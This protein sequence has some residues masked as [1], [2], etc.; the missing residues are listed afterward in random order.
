MTAPM[1]RVK[2]RGFKALDRRMAGA[3]EAMAFKSELVSALGGEVDLSPQRRK[4]VDMAARTALLLD[5]VDAWIVEQRTLVNQRNRTLLPI[6]TQRTHLADHLAR[7]LD[8]LGLDRV[9]QKIVSLEDYVAARYTGEDR[10]PAQGHPGA[11]AHES[12]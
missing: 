10:E 2:L 1:V 4:L 3:R 5:H 7:L 12:E 6:V 11:V 8:R 9:P